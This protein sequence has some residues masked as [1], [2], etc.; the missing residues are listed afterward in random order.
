MSETN[1]EA[2][3]HTATATVDILLR[4]A[5]K[6]RDRA[7]PLAKTALIDMPQFDDDFSEDGLV[8]HLDALDEWIRNPVR[9]RNRAILAGL[10]IATDSLPSELLDDS[11]GIDATADAFRDLKESKHAAFPL[12]LER[13]LIASWLREGLPATAKK[14]ALLGKAREGFSRLIEYKIPDRLR[15]EM[16]VRVAADLTYLSTAEE[17][18][19][20]AQVL[21]EM[22]CVWAPD[23]SP[24]DVNI[25]VDAAY[26]NV[27]TLRELTGT[28]DSAFD[29]LVNGKELRIAADVLKQAASEKEVL[30]SKLLEEWKSLS[31]AARILNVPSASS[32]P[33]RSIPSLEREVEV[34]RDE[35]LRML[36]DDGM[37]I[38]KFLRGEADFPRGFTKEQ[39]EH[40]LMVLRPTLTKA[41]KGILPNAS[42]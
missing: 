11:E 4:R 6:L 9:I 36:G 26:R 27:A 8:G 22:G 42:R 13:G 1:L 29:E 28:G 31:D 40:A 5:R 32:A 25:A 37:L 38:L 39:I 41:L 21:N 20:R 17:L 30:R 14:L 16:V 23:A 24:D 15:D 3:L 7:L 35:C 34:L 10:G 33:P 19:R 18:V 12:L 2:R